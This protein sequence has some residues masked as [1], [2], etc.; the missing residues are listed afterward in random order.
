MSYPA[1]TILFADMNRNIANPFTYLIKA[2][3]P[4]SI[5]VLNQY[6][7]IDI[8]KRYLCVCVCVNLSYVCWSSPQLLYNCRMVMITREQALC[9]IHCAPYNNE[10]AKKYAEM[11]DNLE[12]LEICYIDD[13]MESKFLN[14]CELANN[15]SLS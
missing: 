8:G 9:M 1:L 13:P 7:G 2:S 3:R 12:N 6:I 14:V 11:V 15:F 10:N 4:E 5:Q